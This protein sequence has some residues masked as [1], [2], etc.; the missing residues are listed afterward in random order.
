MNGIIAK[1]AIE[2]GATVAPGQ[3]MFTIM[4]IDSVRVRIGVSE[5]DVGV[6]H[7][8]QAATV[9]APALGEASF[10]GTVSLVGIAADP[11]TRS[12]SVEILVPNGSR[13]LKPGMVAEATVTGPSTRHFLSVPASTVMHRAT[14]AAFVFVYDPHERVVHGRDVRTG[15]VHGDLLFLIVLRTIVFLPFIGPSSISTLIDFLTYPNCA[16][17]LKKVDKEIFFVRLI[18]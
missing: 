17:S 6:M 14:D 1:R 3:P 15:G 2:P 11:T 4:N 13:R 9:T 8:G 7:V 10:L 5:A 16:I 12:Y 18:T